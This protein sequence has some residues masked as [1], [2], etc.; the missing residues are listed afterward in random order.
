MFP[1]GDVMG[2]L[3]T[4]E[5]LLL[6]SLSIALVLF[7]G[8][9][10]PVRAMGAAKVLLVGLT[11]AVIVT[12]AGALVAWGDVYLGDWPG[13][14]YRSV[15]VICIAVGIAV[16]PVIAVVVAVLTSRKMKAA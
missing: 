15:P 8:A 16:Q 14:W 3:L 7:A 10:L 6:A 11:L 2:T 5:S 9:G 12:A 1:A 13:P 4:V